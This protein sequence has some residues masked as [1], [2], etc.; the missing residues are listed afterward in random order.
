MEAACPIVPYS[1]VP[2]AGVEDGDDSLW[3]LRLPERGSKPT[4]QWC[5]QRQLE[6]YIYKVTP[7]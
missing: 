7:P 1:R 5:F 3:I 6:R 2:I 4:K